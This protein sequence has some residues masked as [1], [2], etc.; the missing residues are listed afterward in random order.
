LRTLRARHHKN[1]GADPDQPRHRDQPV[2]HL[3]SAFFSSVFFSSVFGGAGF[4]TAAS[5]PS[6]LTSSAFFFSLS[7]SGGGIGAGSFGPRPIR[8]RRAATTSS[9]ESRRGR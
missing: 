1:A 5:S 8:P 9:R 3:V 2:L 7:G 6:C 4:S